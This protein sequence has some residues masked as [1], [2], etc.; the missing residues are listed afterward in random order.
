MLVLN[1][2]VSM[3]DCDCFVLFAC[4]VCMVCFWF[5]LFVYV[6]I[7][8]VVCL[9]V[10]DAVLQLCVACCCFVADWLFV[11]RCVVLP[12]FLMVG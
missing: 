10:S 1:L 12:A 4:F 7:F 6:C 8:I 3:C 9:L 2:C 11:S 5:V